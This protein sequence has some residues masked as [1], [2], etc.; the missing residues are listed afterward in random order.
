MMMMG[1]NNQL[2]AHK[3]G[4]VSLDSIEKV[5]VNRVEDAVL[6]E[7]VRSHCEGNWNVVQKKKGLTRCENSCRLRRANH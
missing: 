7:H 5:V 6:S 4:G 3:E 2:T 1:G